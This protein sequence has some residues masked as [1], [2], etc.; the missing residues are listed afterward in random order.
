MDD[1]ARSQFLELEESHWWFRGRRE[2]YLD[3][4]A[5]SLGGERLGDVLDVGCGAGAFVRELARV[6]ARVSGV[7]MDPQMLRAAR[8]HGVGRT[9]LARAAEIPFADA[10]FDLVCAFDVLEHLDDDG[11]ALRETLRLLRPRGRLMVSV[12]AYPA[13][14][15]DNDRVSQHRRRYTRSGLERAL[16]DAGFELER[17]T[18]VNA[19]LFPAILPVVLASQLRE[20]LAPRRAPHTHLSWKVP[21]ALNETLRAIFVSERALL[22]RTDLPLGHSLLAIARAPAAMATGASAERNFSSWAA[23][24]VSERCARAGT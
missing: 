14:Y 1:L 5:H 2:L 23:S 22:R 18:H 4:L 13:L 20:R 8:E 21:S 10:S 11:A 7:D 17:S 19:L 16:R 15:S 9:L 6:A 3:V 12:P 24:P